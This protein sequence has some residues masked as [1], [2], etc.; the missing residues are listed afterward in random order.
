MVKRKKLLGFIPVVQSFAG[1]KSEYGQ[2]SRYQSSMYVLIYI[3]AV[4][5]LIIAQ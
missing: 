2:F 5:Y 1:I 3:Y 4:K